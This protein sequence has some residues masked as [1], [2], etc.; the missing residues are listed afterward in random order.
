MLLAA[1]IERLY[2]LNV[3]T[4]PVQEGAPHEKP[5]K[6]LLLMAAFDPQQSAIPDPLSPAAK[7]AEEEPEFGRSPAFRRK[8]LD[9][10]DHQCAACG[11]RIKL[12]AAYDVG[13]IDAAHLIPFSVE[14]ND[15]PTNGLALC[16][17]HHWAMDPNL[18]APIFVGRFNSDQKHFLDYRRKENFLKSA[19]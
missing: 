4:T 7:V 2:D 11:L 8:I 13:F 5:H 12:P 6:P 9:I 17:H 1:A 18:I 19:I 16:T 15:Q 3:G 10:Y 14:P